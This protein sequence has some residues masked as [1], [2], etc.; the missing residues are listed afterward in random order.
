M[1]RIVLSLAVFVLMTFLVSGCVKTHMVVIADASGPS[2]DKHGMLEEEKATDPFASLT[3]DT[4]QFQGPPCPL[5]RVTLPSEPVYQR[6]LPWCWIASAK[7]VM[8]FHKVPRRQ[9][10]LYNTAYQNRLTIAGVTDC[11][12]FDS[13]ET[14]DNTAPDPASLT[15]GTFACLRTGWPDLA[16]KRSGLDFSLRKN[17]LQWESLKN[18]LC[19]QRPFIFVVKF[20]G[21]GGHSQAVKG[22]VQAADGSRVVVVD[23]H[24]NGIKDFPYE[25]GYAQSCEQTPTWT[26]HGNY[27]NIR[28]SSQ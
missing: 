23:D 17:P 9:C 26:H 14:P 24:I 25:C 6:K 1:R 3:D 13:P 28:L 8:A 27:I 10:E 21:G 12:A 2:K 5:T 16:L 4:T 11:C 22:F 7:M 15:T 19:G 20:R 18:Q